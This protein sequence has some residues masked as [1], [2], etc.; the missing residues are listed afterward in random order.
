MA[1]IFFGRALQILLTLVLMKTATTVLG[2]SEF[3][4]LALITSIV[5]FFALSFVNPVG[6]F[7][8]RRFHSWDDDGRLPRHLRSFIL[9]LFGVAVLSSFAV[10][11]AMEFGL[12]EGGFNAWLLSALVGLLVL[13]M[14]WQQTVVPLL[15]MREWRGWFIALTILTLLLNLGFSIGMTALRGP[16]AEAWIFGAIAAN[17]AVAFWAT[18]LFSGPSEYI[19]GNWVPDSRQNRE[20]LRFA[21]PIALAVGLTW[22]Q[23]QSYRFWLED[24]LGVEA[25]GLFVGGYALS[26]GVIAGIE[27][28][29]TAYFQPRFYKK[30]SGGDPN[31]QAEAWN[32]YV[33]ALW[34]AI[35]VTGGFIVGFAPELARVLLGER[36]ADVAIFAAIGAAA[37][38]G[39]VLA[40]AYGLVAHARQ[41]TLLLL[42]PHILGAL[43]AVSILALSSEHSLKGTAL[44]LVISAGMLTLAMHLTM[45]R[46]AKI[47][48]PLTG[49]AVASV[50]AAILAVAGRSVPDA[51]S[52]FGAVGILA[53]AGVAYL[54]AQFIVLREHLR[55]PSAQLSE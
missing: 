3:G 23:T 1:V 41:T 14:C 6:M 26:A 13:G 47:R 55:S 50:L 53:V 49:M 18:L 52:V 37:E 9:Y 39:R 11:G 16:F 20:L 43:T 22:V 34:P 40:A 10:L 2:P 21:W 27:S 54:G 29:L 46:Q 35:L 15:N 51:S 32:L 12:V 5:S 44:A 8:N 45:R 30:V 48:L 4:R 33:S 31:A 42:G 36:F 24:R 25:L 19:R 38:V 7:V 28:I 17:L